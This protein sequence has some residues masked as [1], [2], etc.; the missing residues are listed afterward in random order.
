V[1]TN[2]V[3]GDIPIR[4]ESVIGVNEGRVVRHDGLAAIGIFALSEELANGTQCVRLDGIVGREYDELGDICLRNRKR[5]SNE[6]HAYNHRDDAA[7]QQHECLALTGSK[8]PGGLTLA[9][10]HFGSWHWLASHEYPAESAL[11]IGPMMPLPSWARTRSG[12]RAEN[13]SNWVSIVCCFF[14]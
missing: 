3:T 12:R 8:P 11:E 10:L 4:D 9:Q 2:L 1:I 5:L 13:R 7:R 6:S 14:K